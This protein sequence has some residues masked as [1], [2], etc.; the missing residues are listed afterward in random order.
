[1]RVLYICDRKKC[2][3]C[4]KHCEFTEDIQHAKN[5]E[6]DPLGNF[7]EKSEFCKTK[8]GEKNEKDYLE[9]I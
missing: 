7:V 4:N 8:K 6:Q 9:T 5:F 3:K 1:M 2:Y